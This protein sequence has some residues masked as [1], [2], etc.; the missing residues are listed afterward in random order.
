MAGVSDRVEKGTACVGR[1]RE[2]RNGS[3]GR[4]LRVGGGGGGAGRRGG[5]DCVALGAFVGGLVAR[6]SKLHQSMESWML[7]FRWTSIRDY[8]AGNW[9]APYLANALVY[10]HVRNRG[11]FCLTRNSIVHK[12]QPSAMGDISMNFLSKCRRFVRIVLAV[13]L[14]GS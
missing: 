11:G 3:W 10:F 6:R 9:S 14:V 8:F 4:G 1:C 5:D 13:G 7:R 2:G 12:M